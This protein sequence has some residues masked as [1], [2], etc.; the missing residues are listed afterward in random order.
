ML[1][2]SH[3]LAPLTLVWLIAAPAAAQTDIGNLS[4]EERS[5][6]RAEVRS[7][8]LENPEV[9]MEAI[10]ILEQRRNEAAAEQ[11][12]EVIA[13][14]AEELFESEASYVAGNPEGDVTVVEFLDYRCPYC[15]QAHSEVK[16]LLEED[17][18]VR[19]VVKEYPILGPE[20][21]AAARLAL[22]AL[23]QDPEDFGDLH[24]ALMTYDGQ[25]TEQ[26]AYR[27]AEDQGYDVEKLRKAAAD[28]AIEERIQSNY[29]LAAKLGIQGTPAFVLR[30]RVIPGFVAFDEL[31]A[32]V[33]AQRERAAD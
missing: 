24:E 10:Q 8:L 30:D 3:L 1:R 15:K 9:I 29:A 14:N 20:S 2:L 19:L 28:P 33:D 5:A 11:Q 4:P 6:F 25:L 12:R 18:N 17:P 7:Y 16:R 32:A 13:Q 31:S 21:V 26:A 22:A 27:V 23:E